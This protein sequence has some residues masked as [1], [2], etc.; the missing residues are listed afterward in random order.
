L[1]RRPDRRIADEPTEIWLACSGGNAHGDAILAAGAPRVD[2]VKLGSWMSDAQ[3]AASAT[4]IPALLHIS[5]GVIWPRSRR[6]VAMKVHRT[7]LARTPWVSFHLDLGWTFLAYRWSGP[8]PIPRWVARRWAVQSLRRL[9]AALPVPVLAE[10]MPRW[11]R[12][13]PAYVV[14]PTFIRGAI[15]EADC[16]FLLDLAH[17]RVSADLRRESVHAYLERL[18]LDRVR[19]IHISGPRPSAAHS[20][21]LID[22]HEP[23][24]QEDLDL[25]AWTLKRTQPR[26]V[27]LEYSR[28][29]GPLE[30]Q[31][32]SLRRVLALAPSGDQVRSLSSP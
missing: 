2:R 23:L 21:R 22:A 3:I 27:T 32:R 25:L 10:N 31:L 8:S 1:Q 16:G 18:P 7:R 11:D 30:A 6:W 29:R 5:Q 15:E 24:R 13:G 14:D 28:Q 9:S 4:R 17:A 20:G 26:A 12:A 19:E